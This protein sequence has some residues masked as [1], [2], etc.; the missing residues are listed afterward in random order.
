MTGTSPFFV[1][2]AGSTVAF[3]TTPLD[4]GTGTFHTD[5]GGLTILGVASNKW[6]TTLFTGGTLRMDVANALPT[7]S[8]LKVGGVWYGPNC[9]L[10]LNGFDQTVGSLSRAEPTPGNIV[11]TSS[12][13]A[14]LTLNQ[15]G[16]Y[17]FD[18]AFAGQVSLVKNGAGTLTITNASTSTA[19][20]FVVSNGTLSVA[21]D[22]TLGPNSTNIVVGGTGTLAISNSAVISDRATV[23]IADDGAKINLGSGVNESVGYLVLGDKMR[24]AGTYG[25]SSSAA[26]N[27]DDTHFSGIG[28]L[29]VKHDNSGTIFNIR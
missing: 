6:A 18:G 19:G 28:I 15:S 23:Q 22:G 4:L 11:I 5:S 29:T 17:G 25:S 24:R 14:T 21:S 2:N 10:N 9:T 20:S 16:S 1:V 26:V 7:N 8:L 27:K 3:T 13:P 12:T